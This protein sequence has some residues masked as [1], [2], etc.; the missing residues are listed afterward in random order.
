[1]ARNFDS[2]VQSPNVTDCARHEPPSRDKQ[3]EIIAA[4][5]EGLSIRTM[6]G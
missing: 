1:M 4:L 6:N 3:I 5:T 2:A